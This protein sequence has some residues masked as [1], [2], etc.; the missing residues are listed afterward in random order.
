MSGLRNAY[1]PAPKNLPV[2]ALLRCRAERILL[3]RT[4]HRHRVR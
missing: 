4:Q 2:M 1:A 3:H